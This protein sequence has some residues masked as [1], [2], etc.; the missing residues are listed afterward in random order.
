[1]EKAYWLRR[2]KASLDA[3]Q[4]AVGPEA[5]LAHYD[6]AGRYSVKAALAKAHTAQLDERATTE[7]SEDRTQ[8]SNV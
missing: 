3:A 7:L 5:R 2:K 1:M 8:N 6:L 4:D